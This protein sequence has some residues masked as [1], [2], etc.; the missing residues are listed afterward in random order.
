[1]M[2]LSKAAASLMGIVRKRAFWA[3]LSLL[4]LTYALF[5]L[6]LLP[7]T[8]LL[9]SNPTNDTFSAN[10]VQGTIWQ[11]RAERI[12]W[13]SLSATQVQWHF[14][15]WALFRGVWEYQI[16]LRLDGAPVTGYVGKKLNGAWHLHD[17][18]A[19]LA[20]QK[21]SGV[22]EYLATFSPFSLRGDLTVELE[23]VLWADQWL[24]SIQGRLLL[25]DL[26][27]DELSALGNWAGQISQENDKLIL[28]FN[29]RS[30][31]IQGDGRWV[32]AADRRW[33]LI[34]R[35]KPGRQ[36]DDTL[37]TWFSLLGVPDAEGY[38]PIQQSGRLR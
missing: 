37:V 20:L 21:M 33:N 9:P 3:Y 26:Q 4:V 30:R 13:R 19:K 16:H 8:Y 12:K 2:Q 28:T 7:A 15:P 34:M 5:L 36:A 31:R 27:I 32:L 18:T 24:Q 10:Q 17:V 25:K 14:K 1:M 35:L 23:D 11:G 38:Y 29:P 22:T 6:M